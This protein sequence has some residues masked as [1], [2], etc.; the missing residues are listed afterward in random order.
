ML[1]LLGWVLALLPAVA[2][3]Q[4]AAFLYLYR[5]RFSRRDFTLTDGMQFLAPALESARV[6]EEKEFGL[7]MLT[8][9]YGVPAIVIAVLDLTWFFILNNPSEPIAR[10]RTPMVLGA[11]GAYV[12]VLLNLG[13]RNFRRDITSAVAVWCA[14]TL[15]LGPILAAVVNH[16]AVPAPDPTQGPSFQFASGAVFFLADLA[17]RYVA[18]VVEEAARRLLSPNAVTATSAA[19]R[20]LPLTNIRGITPDIEARLGEEGMVDVYG[21]AMANPNRLLRNTSFDTRQIVN[22]MD[23]ALLIFYVKFWEKLEDDGITGAIDLAWYYIG[24]EQPGPSAEL[25]ERPPEP[26]APPPPDVPAAQPPPPAGRPPDVP[27][28]IAALAARVGVDPP[29]QL[30]DIIKRLYTDAQVQ[31]IWVLYQMQPA[32][33]HDVEK[34]QPAQTQGS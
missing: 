10:F 34:A 33:D 18:S 20:T 16:L 32:G 19:P 9:R 17:P 24:L 2:I 13:Q 12:Y 7:P 5:T 22:W 25:S 29:Q 11:T 21:L 8:L 28:D 30:N 27:P 26:G 4:H 1:D 6:S 14:A 23:E 15:A 3:L 31:Q